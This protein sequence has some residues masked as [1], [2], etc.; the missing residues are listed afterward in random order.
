MVAQRMRLMSVCTTMWASCAL[1]PSPQPCSEACC[2]SLPRTRAARRAG[3]ARAQGRGR[4]SRALTPR[5]A[6]ARRLFETLDPTARRAALPSGREVILSDTVGFISDL[7]TQLV[8]AFQARA[9][10]AGPA[11]AIA[12]HGQ[13]VS[14][15]DGAWGARRRARVCRPVPTTLGVGAFCGACA[16]GLGD[17]V[18]GAAEAVGPRTL[19]SAPRARP[20]ARRLR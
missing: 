14:V 3:S 16:P 10:W 2:S 12:P 7:P 11:L 17:S 1:T 4:A 5:G 19:C 9:Q 15:C 18:Q 8:R 20:R 6:R 13:E